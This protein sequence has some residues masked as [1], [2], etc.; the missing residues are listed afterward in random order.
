MPPSLGHASIAPQVAT[1]KLIL[2]IDGDAIS[3]VRGYRGIFALAQSINDA[4][5]LQIVGRHLELDAITGRK[6][7]ESLAHFSG[8]M[9]K[10]QMLIREFNAE[11]C[12]GKYTDD[13]TFGYDWGVGRHGG[14]GFVRT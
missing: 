3:T 12:S 14:V 11:H 13:F 1:S 8:Y 2:R 4:R 7:N 9:C 6:A 5:L 10:H